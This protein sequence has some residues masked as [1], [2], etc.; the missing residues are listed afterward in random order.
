MNTNRN[1]LRF[2]PRYIKRLQVQLISSWASSTHNTRVWVAEDAGACAQAVCGVANPAFVKAEHSCDYSTA[3]CDPQLASRL[4]SEL[5]ESFTHCE[6]WQRSPP[7]TV[8][9]PVVQQGMRSAYRHCSGPHYHDAVRL[10]AAPAP[11]AWSEG[12]AGQS[13]RF[14]S[15]IND[16]QQKSVKTT[17]VYANSRL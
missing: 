12:L 9:S 14:V 1:K 2:E 10:Y 5:M 8:P 15:I 4:H 6:S 17:S 7:A 16:I 11:T 13:K 3:Q